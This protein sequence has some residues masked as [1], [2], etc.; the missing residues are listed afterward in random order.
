MDMNIVLFDIGIMVK[1]N[2]HYKTYI[3]TMPLQRKL[4]HNNLA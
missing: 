2:I 3:C 4:S 1:V